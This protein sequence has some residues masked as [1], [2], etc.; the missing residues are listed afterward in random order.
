MND[1]HVE[2]ARIQGEIEKHLGIEGNLIFDFVNEDNKVKLNLVTINK[3]HH[4]SFLFHTEVGLDKLEALR[5]MLDYVRTYRDKEGSYTL[6]WRVNGEKELHTS[7]FRAKNM[8]EALDKF[9][10]NRD[11]ATI[12]VFSLVL[13]PVS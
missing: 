12:T 1:L 9:Y 5:K 13:N 7:Y 6:Q 3:R 11:M 10:Y 4:Q 2:T 8:Y